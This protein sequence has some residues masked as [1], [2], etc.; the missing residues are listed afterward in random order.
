MKTVG[1][2]NRR[3]KSGSDEDGK[4]AGGEEERD[5][6]ERGREEEEEKGKGS[7]RA[8]DGETDG[9]TEKLQPHAAFRKR[10]I[11]LCFCHS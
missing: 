2:G 1:D 8:E 9:Q 7:E 6:R 10:R 4:Q 3:R 11:L 5:E